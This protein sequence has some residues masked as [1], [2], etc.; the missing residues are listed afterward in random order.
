ME[1]SEEEENE[2]WKCSLFYKSWTKKGTL[3]HA[4]K[5]YIGLRCFLLSVGTLEGDMESIKPGCLSTANSI[6]CQ[7]IILYMVF[8]LALRA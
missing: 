7:E 1:D 2:E 8:I 6:W 5:E 4:I 3:F